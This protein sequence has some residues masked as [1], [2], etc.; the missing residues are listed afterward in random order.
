[1]EIGLKIW[2]VREIGDNIAVFDWWEESNCYF[3]FQNIEGPR[4][5]DTS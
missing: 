5:W 2:V 3:E 1:M 4:K